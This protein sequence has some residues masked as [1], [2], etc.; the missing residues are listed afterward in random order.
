M[1]ASSS[2]FLSHSSTNDPLVA[3]LRIRLQNRGYTVLEDSTFPAGAILRDTVKSH[4]DNADHVVGVVTPQAAASGWV[5]RELRYAQTV[6]R[7][8]AGYRIIPLLVRPAG[9]PEL[10]GIFEL[11]EP[12]P[13]ADLVD[14][15]AELIAIDVGEGAGAIDALIPAL[16]DA[17]EGNVAGHVP[18]LE[19]RSGRKATASSTSIIAFPSAR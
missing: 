9:T 8:R 3:A 4:I 16:I 6:A 2:I 15:P 13:G 10:R 19:L 5:K 14:W 11:P 1:S 18:A 17:L 12:D 7:Q